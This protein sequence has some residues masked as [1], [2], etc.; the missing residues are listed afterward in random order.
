LLLVVMMMMMMMMVVVMVEEV[1]PFEVWIKT[2]LR[3]MLLLRSQ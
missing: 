1:E 2:M 3:K